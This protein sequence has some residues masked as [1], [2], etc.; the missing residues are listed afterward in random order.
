VTTSLLVPLV[1]AG[2]LT[3]EQ[4]FPY[5]LGANIGTTV[6]ALLAAFATA[7]AT[8]EQA[9]LGLTV[10]CAH[11]LLN[12]LGASIFYPL[13]WIPISMAR[14]LATKA[15]ESKRYAAFFVLGVFFGIPLIGI[16]AHWLITN[17]LK[18]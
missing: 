10:A 5:L 9:R 8:E 16:A 15:A 13:R 6:T 18:G 12:A 14:G 4:V 2:L 11:T 3:L 1:A 17:V 7:A